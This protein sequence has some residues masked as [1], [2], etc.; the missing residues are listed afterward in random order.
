MIYVNYA[1]T[2]AMNP[3]A[4]NKMLE[5]IQRHQRALEGRRAGGV[6]DGLEQDHEEQ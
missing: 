2:E 1:E 6:R 3:T 4:M 5:G